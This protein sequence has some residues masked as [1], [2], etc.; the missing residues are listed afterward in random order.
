MT[1]KGRTAVEDYQEGKVPR[2]EPRNHL[3]LG[4]T[5]LSQIFWDF[6]LFFLGSQQYFYN[7]AHKTI[8]SLIQAY[9]AISTDP[10]PAPISCTTSTI[11]DIREGTTLLSNCYMLTFSHFQGLDGLTSTNFGP[12]FLHTVACYKRP[13]S[14]R[15]RA[16]RELSIYPK[17]SF[18]L[19]LKAFLA[20]RWI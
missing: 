9:L 12:R 15:P 7:I 6:S 3:Y 5:F 17:V 19:I 4:R 1:R 20:C 18:C 11:K 2:R 14:S 10:N 8:T 13:F 16:Y